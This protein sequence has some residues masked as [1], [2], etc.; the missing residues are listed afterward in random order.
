MDILNIINAQNIDPALYE[1]LQ[2]YVERTV[3]DYGAGRNLT[4]S[5]IDRM[6][7]EVMGTPHLRRNPPNGYNQQSL[8]EWVRLLILVSLFN[9][10]GY[11]LN[12][13][14]QIYYGG[15]PYFLLPLFRPGRPPNPPRPP[16]PPRPPFPP[17]GGGP[18]RPPGGGP[19][20]PPSGGPSRPPSGGPGRPPGGGPGR[21]P[22]G[23][24]G[25]PPSGGPGRP[26]R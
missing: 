21:P 10:Y 3:D 6:V 23:G 18:G 12:P 24:P 5:D 19:G 8:R 15:I 11:N 7:D 2:P 4:E 13:F 22:G 17:P 25:R 16:Q 26:P 9:N 1:E 14:W 20:R